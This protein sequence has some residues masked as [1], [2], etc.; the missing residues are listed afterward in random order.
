M[1]SCVRDRNDRRRWVSKRPKRS[2]VVKCPARS[3]LKTREGHAQK[4]SFQMDQIL[5]M[6]LIAVVA[7]A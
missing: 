1:L 7:I 5:D 2:V 3:R 4:L 6:I